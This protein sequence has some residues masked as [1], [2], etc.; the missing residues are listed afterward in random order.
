MTS[1]CA[2]SRRASLVWMVAA[3]AMADNRARAGRRRT[4]RAPP[5]VGRRALRGRPAR[6]ARGI[7]SSAW[8]GRN[9]GGSRA[10]R[11]RAQ[12]GSAMREGERGSTHTASAINTPRY[13]LRMAANGKCV[14]WVDDEA[15]LLEPHRMFLRDKGFNVES[16]THADDAA[17]L[18]RRRPFDLVLLDEQ[19]PGRRGLDAFREFREISPNVAVVMVTKSEEDTTLMEAL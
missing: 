8:R 15:E 18:L 16:A 3:R 7:G 13:I 2:Q 6:P 1:R 19:M 4:S 14:L 5:L 12:S 17:E 11:S 9:A 10:W